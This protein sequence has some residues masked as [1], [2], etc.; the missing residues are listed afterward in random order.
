MEMKM[1][2]EDEICTPVRAHETDAGLDLIC[3]E[4]VLIE[5]GGNAAIDTGVHFEIPE[6]YYGKLES[7]SGLNF[8]EDIVC[9][10]GVIDSGYTGEVRVK[11]YN[12]GKKDVTIER[13]QKCVQIIFIP[14]IA[15]ELVRTDKF[16]ETCRGDNGFGSTGK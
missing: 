10:G 16:E 15:P 1:I 11:L 7:K 2:V 5:A 6:G 12:M 13:G 3:K 9:L 8:K 14:Y 4:S